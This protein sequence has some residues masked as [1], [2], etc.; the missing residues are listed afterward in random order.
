MPAT[1]GIE[2]RLYP[3]GHYIRTGDADAPK[4]IY[5]A[6]AMKRDGRG[7]C[8][9]CYFLLRNQDTGEKVCGWEFGRAEQELIPVCPFVEFDPDTEGRTTR[10]KPEGG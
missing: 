6:H 1:D 7:L 2:V 3:E 8:R 9:E 5:C 10:E 4:F